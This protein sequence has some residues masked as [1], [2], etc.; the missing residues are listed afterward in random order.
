[1]VFKKYFLLNFVIFVKNQIYVKIFFFKLFNLKQPAQ[2]IDIFLQYFNHIIRKKRKPFIG[3]K[4]R[5]S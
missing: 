4:S 3:K 2:I 1:M 5:I